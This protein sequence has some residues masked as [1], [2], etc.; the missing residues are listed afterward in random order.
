MRLSVVVAAVSLC[1]IGL[2]VADDVRASIRRPTNIPAQAL[3][4]ALE[5]L[6]KDRNFQVVYV[7]EELNGLR[8]YGA[9]GE[10]TSEEA[11]KQLLAGTGMTFRYLDENTVT[12]VR[13]INS[14]SNSGAAA[15]PDTTPPPAST[16]GDSQQE[17]KKSS[18]EQFRVAQVDQ[19]QTANPSP[20]EQ[21]EE[22]TSQRKPTQVEEI[23]VTGSRL[24]QTSKETATPV[25][26]LTRED[27]DDTGAQSVA[28]ALNTLSQVSVNSTL[29][30]ETGG[31]TGGST[32]QLRGL[33]GGTTLVLLNGRRVEST[34]LQASTFNLNSIPLAA[35][36]RIEV[37]P[38]GSSAIY[39]GDALGGV[40]NI[41]LKKSFSGL[42]LDARYGQADEYSERD[43]SLIW[44]VAGN[45]GDLAVIGSYQSNNALPAGARELSGNLDFRPYGGPDNRVTYTPLANIYS[46]NGQN[47]PGLNAQFAAVPLGFTGKPTIQEFR[48]TAGTLNTGSQ[49]VDVAS[50]IPA[51]QQ[52]GVFVNGDYHLTDK[53]DAFTEILYSRFRFQNTNNLNALTF[54]EYGQFTATAS[55][56]YNPFG[57]PVGVDLAFT[58]LPPQCY[59]ID[60]DFLRPLVG[61]RGSLGS[62]WDWEVAGWT[63]NDWDTQSFAPVIDPAKA[64]AALASS[65][66]AT[67]LNVFVDGPPGSPALLNSLLA[68]TSAYTFDSRGALQSINGF[69]RGP[70]LNLPAGSIQALIGAEYEHNTLN[71]SSFGTVANAARGR[72]AGFSE[73]K[74]PIISNHAQLDSGQI[75]SLSG[76]LRYD[77]YSDVG[78]HVS[79]QTGLELRPLQSLLLRAEYS[80]AFKPGGLLDLFAP[81]QTFPGVLISDSQRGGQSYL[82]TGIEGGN[83]NLKPET[84]W[85]TSI[86]LVFSPPWSEGLIASVTDWRTHLVNGFITPDINYLIAN[87]TAFPGTVIRSPPTAQD[88]ANGLPGLIQSINISEVNFGFLD[89]EGVDFKAQWRIGSTFGELQPMLTAT[90]TYRYLVNDSPNSPTTNNVSVANYTAFAPRWKGSLGLKWKLK[91]IQATA[92]GRYVGSY[93]DYGPLPNGTTATLGNVWYLDANIRYEL[94]NRFAPNN[95]YLRGTYVVLSGVNLLNRLPDYSTFNPFIGYDPAEYDIR[96]RLV[97]VQAVVKY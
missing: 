11:L 2:A 19:G 70:L 15:S 8:T 93:Q 74:I 36:E 25:T 71:F 82:V 17:G 67:A 54:G 69:L 76:A 10:F 96:G 28:D 12:I 33:P 78:S 3:G 90:D 37:L 4:S 68:P 26:I 24:P 73:V 75:L 92:I 44:G 27:I 72:Y 29:A 48:S 7:T 66:P 46:L 77:H 86:G 22:Q 1:L 21:K 61:L 57:V 6:A 32:V 62:S 9:V 56:P 55:N 47:L 18:S 79:G 30:P 40:V 13:S 41:I 63:S 59:C 34:G 95:T 38:E 23:V 94:G 43:E 87:P 89:L 5:A 65:N 50:Q 91:D 60:E 58:G 31:S 51:S 49:Y 84:G 39:G 83:P 88:I 20:V 35:V 64:S 80:T 85:S 97:S 14:S 42:A 16:P 53:V 45:R 52:Y 81:Q